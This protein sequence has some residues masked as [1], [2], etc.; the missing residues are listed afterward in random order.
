MNGPGPG[1]GPLRA[2]PATPAAGAYSPGIQPPPE[3]PPLR[4]DLVGC[5]RDDGVQDLRILAGY[6]FADPAPASGGPVAGPPA[7]RTVPGVS[8]PGDAGLVLDRYRLEE[9]LGSGGFAIV[10]RARHLLLQTPVAIKLLRPGH[11]GEADLEALCEEARF[12]AMVAHPNVVRVF[13]V[14]RNAETAY[15]VMEYVDGPSLAHVIRD[16]GPL[17]PLSALDVA[18]G[19]CDGLAAALAC[20]L[21]HRDVK[22]G[23]LLIRSDHQVLL[24]D[25]GLARPHG[26]VAGNRPDQP[27]IA[28]TPAYMAP[29]QALNPD[30]IDHRAD[31]YALGATLFHLLTGRVPYDE[32]DPLQQI[33]RHL[34]AAVPDPR[35]LVDGLPD[36]LADLVM[37]LLVKERAERPADYRE[38]R[39]LLCQ[40]RDGL[41]RS[42]RNPR[43][44]II[45]RLR[46]WFQ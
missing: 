16:Q 40:V 46:S 7:V 4:V 14:V 11:G 6:C 10:Y 2:M 23:N 8:D 38:L 35:A 3:P 37:G 20:G 44:G 15:I 25:F 39:Q 13:D 24:A 19:A 31:M 32:N 33:A 1:G 27:R 29:E 12:A 28:G 21:I 43:H 30:D 22:P 5:F 17:D 9:E 26:A 41:S 18:L 42:H 34:H 45:N 36:E